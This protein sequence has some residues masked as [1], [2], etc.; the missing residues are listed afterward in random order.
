MT[1]TR[2]KDGN[3]DDNRLVKFVIVTMV[4]PTLAM[5]FH[6]LVMVPAA[7]AQLLLVHIGGNPKFWPIALS[8]LALLPACWGAFA[9][10]KWAWPGSK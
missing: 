6:L 9:V 7:F 10:C 3:L 4:F 1:E 8:I 2:D 5:A